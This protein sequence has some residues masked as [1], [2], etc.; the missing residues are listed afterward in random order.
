MLRCH[1]FLIKP[2]L[3]WQ[4]HEPK[5]AHKNSILLG[6]NLLVDDNNNVFPWIYSIYHNIQITNR[7]QKGKKER[8]NTG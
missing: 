7:I 2:K 8:N 3:T 6:Q 5:L 1:N 4:E